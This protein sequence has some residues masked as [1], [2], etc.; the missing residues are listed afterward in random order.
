MLL[1]TVLYGPVLNLIECWEAL[2]SEFNLSVSS[3]YI[4]K[5]ALKNDFIFNL[6]SKSYHFLNDY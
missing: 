6:R 4:Y 1:N 2:G 5:K 3:S